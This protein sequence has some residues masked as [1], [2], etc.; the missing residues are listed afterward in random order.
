MHFHNISLFVAR[1]LRSPGT[2]IKS[3]SILCA[4]LK[5]IN[6]LVIYIIANGSE[7]GLLSVTTYLHRRVR[8]LLRALSELYRRG[9]VVV[10]SSKL[11]NAL[12][13]VSNAWANCCIL[14]KR[15]V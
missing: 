9:G 12:R 13:T 3:S 14:H 8:V 4:C 6:L 2:M 7:L 1:T 10:S 15:C 11:N 5:R